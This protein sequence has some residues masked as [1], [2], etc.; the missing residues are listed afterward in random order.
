MIGGGSASRAF[1]LRMRHRFE[2]V[3]MSGPTDH[4]MKNTR[5]FQMQVGG[6]QNVEK[7][8]YPHH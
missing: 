6:H 2:K 3:V 8:V 4:T 1:E 5:L 7:A